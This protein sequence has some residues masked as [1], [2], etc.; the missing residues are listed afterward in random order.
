GLAALTSEDDAG[1][2]EPEAGHHPGDDLL[3]GRRVELGA[4]ASD[5]RRPDRDERERPVP[6][7]GLA[8]LTLPPHRVAEHRGEHDPS[9]EHEV[10]MHAK[11][12]PSPWRLRARLT[13]CAT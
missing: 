8:V 7:G 9:E 6:G 4:D 2:E 12:K 3:R 1:S 11:P 5:A 10:G 13:A